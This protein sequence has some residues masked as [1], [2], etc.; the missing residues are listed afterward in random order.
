MGALTLGLVVSD[1]WFWQSDRVPLHLF[2]GGII[3]FLLYAMC[4]HGYESVNWYMILLLVY[5][6]L[7]PFLYSMGEFLYGFYQYEKYQEPS[8]DND[9]SESTRTSNNT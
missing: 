8:E 9:T 5:L 2:L 4:Q 3:T 6:I 1:L 7:F